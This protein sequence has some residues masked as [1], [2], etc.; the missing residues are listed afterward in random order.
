[1]RRALKL[2][3]LVALGG[4]AFRVEVGSDDP[5][6]VVVGGG[7]GS[8]TF[9][10]D[11]QLSSY[12]LLVSETQLPVGCRVD[13]GS[14]AVLP[15]ESFE[16]LWVRARTESTLGVRGMRP[17]VLGDA[18][19]VFPVEAIEGRAIAD[20]GAGFSFFV[21]ES[22][23]TRTRVDGPAWEHTATTSF[24]F[25][26]LDTPFTTGE[27]IV[28]SEGRCIPT[29]T[30]T[31]APRDGGAP[32]CSVT[33]SFIAELVAPDA[34]WF[35][36]E[37]G[38]VGAPPTRLLVS[39]DWPE[40]EGTFCWGSEPPLSSYRVL[41]RRSLE[42]WL[43]DGRAALLNARSIKLG[44]APVITLG[45]FV[46]VAPTVATSEPRP[47]ARETRTTSVTVTSG[48]CGA[49][50]PFLDPRST[51]ELRSSWECVGGGCPLVTSVDR[52]SCSTQLRYFAVPLQGAR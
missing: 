37:P 39:L 8:G 38:G 11:T 47:D 40:N 49:L 16:V 15:E 25:D 44:D 21:S 24:L 20:G 36:P 2:A 32:D 22:F 48:A 41:G 30:E 3:G 27:L 43:T 10:D 9:C 35:Q 19:V 5:P 52:G 45:P 4:C 6:P 28:A 42:V 18:P 50:S 1:M 51:L 33:R 26:R 17:Q 46:P 23:T 12:R 7:G 31:C 14:P 13:A 29:S 34:G